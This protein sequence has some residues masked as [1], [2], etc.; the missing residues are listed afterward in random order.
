MWTVGVTKEGKIF[1]ETDDFG[2]NIVLW[3]DGEFAEISDHIWF[4]S[5]LARKL[6]GTL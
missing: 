4:A 6:N 1:L 2:D 5:N 3:V